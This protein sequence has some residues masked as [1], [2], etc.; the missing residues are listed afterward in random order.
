MSDLSLIEA[1]QEG[2][3]A[4]V[5]ERLEAGEDVNQRDLHQKTPLIH[6]AE[7]GDVGLVRWLIARGADPNRDTGFR[8]VLEEARDREM[9]RLL[10]KAGVQEPIRRNALFHAV[11]DGRYDLAKTLAD[12]LPASESQQHRDGM[13]L[14]EAVQRADL[15]L[16][17]P[18]ARQAQGSQVMT[19]YG[20]PALLQALQHHD[21]PKRGKMAKI[22]LSFGAET[23]G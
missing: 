12:S 20:S 23:H 6:A 16:L 7:R 11:A 1:F 17:G 2:D 14:L 10:L 5:Q 9:V 18:L 13:A 22:L 8:S 19:D 21:H 3:L 15:K 4:A